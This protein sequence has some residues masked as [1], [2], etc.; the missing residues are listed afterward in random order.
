MISEG[1][2]E[3]EDWSNDAEKITFD[4]TGLYY[5]LITYSNSYFKM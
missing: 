2:C 4:I 1:S 5:I 3:T